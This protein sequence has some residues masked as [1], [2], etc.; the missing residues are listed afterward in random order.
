MQ[1]KSAIAIAAMYMAVP[2]F[3]AKLLSMNE[4]P[5]NTLPQ[6]CVAILYK[7]SEGLHGPSAVRL[8]ILP[9]GGESFVL[10]N[11]RML[12]VALDRHCHPLAPLDPPAGFTYDI[13]AKAWDD[14]PTVE[15]IID[16]T[17]ALW[18]LRNSRKN[19]RPHSDYHYRGFDEQGRMLPMPHRHNVFS[20]EISIQFSHEQ[21]LCDPL[22]GYNPLHG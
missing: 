12:V 10:H 18:D 5:P 22:D 17:I 9:G 15:D 20:C 7:K 6:T 14:N 4:F 2:A 21:Y 1:F 13:K 3:A 19:K 11:G 8:F 16:R